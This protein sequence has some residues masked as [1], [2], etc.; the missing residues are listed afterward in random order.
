MNVSQKT[1]RALAGKVSIYGYAGV[2][3][4]H[5]SQ[6]L[7]SIQLLGFLKRAFWLA[8]PIFACQSSILLVWLIYFGHLTKTTETDKR[9][10]I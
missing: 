9:A 3:T 8:F 5:V 7:S 2:C 6:Q 4:P 10:Q 1:T